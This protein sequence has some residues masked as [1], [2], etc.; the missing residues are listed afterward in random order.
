MEG[1][2]QIPRRLSKISGIRQNLDGGVM[3]GVAGG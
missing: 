1:C 3:A 2:K